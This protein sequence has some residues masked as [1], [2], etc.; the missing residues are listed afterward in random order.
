MKLLINGAAGFIGHALAQRMLSQGYNVI[1]IDNLN[2]YYDVSLKQARLDCLSPH[3]AFSFINA[4]IADRVAMSALFAAQKFDVVINLAAQA[5]VRYS[6]EN[7]HAYIDA[8]I[9]GFLNILEGCRHSKVGHLVF[10]SSSSVY[11]ANTTLP[12]N[13]SHSVDHPVS[14]YA[15][16]KKANELMAHSYA[17]LYGVACTGLRLFTVYGPWGRP[18]MALF[19]FTKSILA[20][21][22]VQVFNHGKMVRDFTYIDDVVEAIMRLAVKP[23]TPNANWSGATPDPASSD[24]PYCIYNLGNSEPIE[25]M[26]YIHAIETAVGKP[27]LLQ[28]LPMQSGD[29][30]A[31]SAD[32]ARLEQAIGFRPRTRVED[33]VAKFV[34]W[35]R[36]YYKV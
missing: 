36:A 10:A 27:A 6:L 34:T 14:L 32:I 35:Y 25:L 7:P 23:A 5:G 26:R 28:M 11:G 4:D 17:S 30:L 33:G 31:T 12:F 19:K 29:V 1:G 3:S 8:N 21:E 9:Q 13:E 22:P 15:A 24:A 18:D 16:T 2:D 20:G